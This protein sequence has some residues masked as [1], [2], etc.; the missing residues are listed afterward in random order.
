[1]PITAEMGTIAQKEHK[2][3][4]PKFKDESFAAKFSAEISPEMNRK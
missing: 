2:R 1:M 4:P 3:L